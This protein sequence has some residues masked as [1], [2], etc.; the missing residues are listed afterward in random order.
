MNMCEKMG[1]NLRNLLL[2]IKIITYQIVFN[3]DALDLIYYITECF[4]NEIVL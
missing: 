3:V 1:F 2:N 4:L